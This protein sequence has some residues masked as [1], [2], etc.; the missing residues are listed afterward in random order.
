MQKL[1]L[2]QWFALWICA[3]VMLIVLTQPDERADKI[4]TISFDTTESAQRYFTN[5]RS[6]Y[7]HLTDE[8]Q[9]MLQVYRL[10][11][12]FQNTSQTFIPFAIYD[13]WRTNE[14]MIRIDTARLDTQM[15][16]SLKA[17]SPKGD[18]SEITFPDSWN[19]SQYE[20][21]RVVYLALKSECS[22]S[23][24]KA[25]GIEEPL[26]PAAMRDAKRTLTDY[27]HLTGKI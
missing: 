9:G 23:L 18:V 27:F 22:F 26:S 21:A 20:F 5:V 6:F 16:T 8:G 11:T 25:S 1:S 19:E 10:K 13:N 12:L 14:A 7:Y 2:K 3:M 4:N 15:W 17:V 24:V